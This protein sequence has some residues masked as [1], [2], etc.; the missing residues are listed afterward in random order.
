MLKPREYKPGTVI[1]ANI[2]Q[3][4]GLGVKRRYVKAVEHM[5]PN[6]ISVILPCETIAGY[7]YKGKL[8]LPFRIPASEPLRKLLLAVGPLV[9]SSANNP[10]CPPSTTVDGAVNYFHDKVDFYVDGGDLANNKP[11]TII[12]VIDDS[13]EVIREGAVKIDESTGRLFS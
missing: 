12:R 9:T 5:W 6:P 11:S 4:V 1:A 8:S 2:D 3:I 13:I 7:L 10:D